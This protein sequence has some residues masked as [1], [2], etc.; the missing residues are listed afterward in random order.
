[1]ANESTPIS[2][3]DINCA[4]STHLHLLRCDHIETVDSS[5]IEYG[6][7]HTKDVVVYCGEF[8]LA[9]A[10]LN[11]TIVCPLKITVDIFYCLSSK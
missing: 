11:G 1:M 8:S 7:D 2:L 3:T 10:Q 9:S 6:C 5:G 4:R